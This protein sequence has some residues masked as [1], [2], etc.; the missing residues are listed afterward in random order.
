MQ[1]EIQR[2][3][4]APLVS[5]VVPTFNREKALVRCLKSLESQTFKNFEV[6][7][8]D[9]GSTDNTRDAVNQFKEIL[10]LK[11]L[12]QENFG[13]PARARNRGISASSGKYIAFLDS[14]D[15]WKPNKLDISVR[16]LEQGS[17]FV[18]HDLHLFYANRKFRFGHG[19]ANSK[20]PTKPVFSDLVCN[21]NRIVNSSVVVRKD[22]LE[23]AG[24]ISESPDLGAAEDY[25]LWLRI[26]KIT[27]QFTWIPKLLGFYEVSPD[28][29]STGQRT[30]RHLM[31]FRSAYA[32]EFKQICG[33][34][35]W[36]V[37]YR[38][39]KA[40]LRV[41]DPT[42]ARKSARSAL[43]KSNTVKRFV[44][45]AWLYITTTYFAKRSP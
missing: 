40:Q 1:R 30:V 45:S 37:S 2:T 9:D 23:K 34:E 31:Y 19:K 33:G 42:S 32:H 28:S 27:D 36:W 29:I 16:A 3:K 17:D 38:L 13:R 6:I 5:V 14:D 7:V 15:W 25:E 12:Y 26:A 43:Q 18:C 20:P 8:C 39:S 35:P 11:Y 21:G 10:T 22:I 24:P 41:G 4:P 44:A